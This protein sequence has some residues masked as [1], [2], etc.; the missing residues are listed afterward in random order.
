VEERKEVD[1]MEMQEM[2]PVVDEI[3]VQEVVQQR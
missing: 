1:E 3:Q 2:V